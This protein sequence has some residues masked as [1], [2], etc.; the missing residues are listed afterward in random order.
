LIKLYKKTIPCAGISKN[1]LN[2]IFPEF[3]RELKRFSDK[4]EL[5][6]HTFGGFPILQELIKKYKH[7]GIQ[8][9]QLKNALLIILESF[10][11]HSEK[12]RAIKYIRTHLEKQ[13]LGKI[14]LPSIEKQKKG[15]F[16]TT[17]KRVE[18]SLSVLRKI[19]MTSLKILKNV[20]LFFGLWSVIYLLSLSLSPA[21]L[22]TSLS[23]LLR[24][25]D[26]GVFLILPSSAIAII[27]F[28]ILK[29]IEN[30]RK[31]QKL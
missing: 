12:R 1:L 11:I 18:E 20:G 31:V 19:G 4:F 6:K 16:H 8:T 14:K 17:R 2:R 29:I 9:S 25:S 24:F 7:Q 13:I 10:T 21:V 15:R 27:V 28:G 23:Y 30:L 5:I 22:G 3:K 26:I